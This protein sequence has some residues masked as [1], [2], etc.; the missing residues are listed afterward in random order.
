MRKMMLTLLSAT[1]GLVMRPAPSLA[2][3][4]R[5]PANATAV[6]F[7][8]AKI[9]PL[10]VDNCYNCHSADT[11]AKGG[12][13]VDDRNGLLTGGDRGPA[14]VPRDPAR[15]RLIEA[16]SYTNPKLQ[17]PPKKQLSAQQVADL[18]TWI[19]D[20]AAWPGEVLPL[21]NFQK[22]NV[23]YE[24]LRRDHWAWQPIRDA[25]PPAVRNSAWPRADVDR[26]VLATLEAKGLIP[27]RDANREDLIR[28]VSFDLTGLP[29]SPR[30]IDAFIQ[31]QSPDAFE[32]VVDRQL[33][34]P[35]FGERWGRHWLDVARYA[36]STGPSR[37]IP[38][39]QAW[40]YRDFVID[41]L[42]RDKP[43]D[44]FVREQVA[45]DLLPAGSPRERDEHRIA[46]GFLAIGPKDVN[47]RFR[48]RFE[49]DNVDEQIDT[50]S[51]SV[52]AVTASCARCH[53]HKFDPIP[54][55]DYY[56]L[57]GIFHS[58]DD[59]AGVRNKM[60]GSGLDYYDTSMLV[61]LSTTKPSPDPKRVE[62]V[63]AAYEKAKA[64]WDAIRGTP[65]GLAKGPNGQPVQRPYRLKFQSLQAEW[66]ELTDPAQRNDVT[67]GLRDAQTVGDTQIRLRGEAEKLGPTVPRGFLS[68]L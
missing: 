4:A 33:A 54:Q 35:A 28:R 63:T 16:V 40:R 48:V 20:G 44:Q 3:E 36:E 66:L 53:D 12:L 38:Y 8:E 59:C 62:E 18:T 52:L 14:V 32:K 64:E 46:T 41:S 17:M 6:A 29:P 47:Q 19:Q 10:L 50:V 23:R 5:D 27:V 37:N 67:L 58:T 39:P 13:R 68:V 45:G 2:A 61:T 26:F 49:M 65:R 21:A 31:D 7:F 24:Q 11:N 42:N 9:R 56:A 43:F 60:G 25:R 51:R 55:A 34:S 1:A 15:S 57:A 22:P 30:Q